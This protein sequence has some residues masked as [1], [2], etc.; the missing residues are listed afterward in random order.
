MTTK[1]FYD[2]IHG[3]IPESLREMCTIYVEASET[4]AKSI[5]PAMVWPERHYKITVYHHTEDQFSKLLCNSNSHQSLS[6]CYHDALKQLQ[7][8]EKEEL[9]KK[10]DVQDSQR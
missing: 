4:Y 3:A 1:E 2:L 8:V 7:K 10:F 6:D 9:E 5:K